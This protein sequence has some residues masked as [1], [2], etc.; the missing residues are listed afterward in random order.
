[1][2]TSPNG[3]AGR[4]DA[5]ARVQLAR[6]PERPHT[7]DYIGELCADFVELYGDR[8][9][10]EDPAIVGGLA[11]FAGR[12]VMV[13]GHQKGANTKENLRRHFGMAHPEGY[14]KARRLMK[15][16]EKFGL[17]VLA[18][19]DTPGADPGLA[20]EERGQSL[21]IAACI[22]TLTELRVPV[23][24]TVIGEAGSGGA[25][26]LG[27]ADQIIMLENAVYT[28][29]SPEGCASI[30][31]RSRDEA[32]T[33]AAAMRMTAPDQV[34][35]GVVDLVIAEPGEGAHTD[36]PA[37][38]KAV[39]S[40]I[41]SALHR[42]TGLTTAELLATRYARLRGMGAYLYTGAGAA[43]PREEPSLRR[44]LGRILHLPGVPRRPRW[45][46]I[47]P[48][49]GADDDNERGA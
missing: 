13:L 3:Q 33:A 25:L 37:T 48:S 24:A 17:P 45:S 43:Q 18:F 36:H 42:L 20:S 12:T 34:D 1:M 47:W 27:V 21:A 40:A 41:L 44:R 49:D 29:I 31:W 6:Q 39:K 19:I 5:W 15:H 46:E 38:A 16:A 28:V 30:L 26:A 22:E 2:G 11:R 14:H 35:L 7:L 32:R 10:R 23:V 9:F 8:A 4:P